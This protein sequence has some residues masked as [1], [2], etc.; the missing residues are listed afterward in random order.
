V[1]GVSIW[2]GDGVHLTANTT[3]SR[4]ESS[5]PTL[6]EADKA[7]S[8][9]TSVPA[10]SRLSRPRSPQAKRRLPRTSNLRRRFRRD[11]ARHHCGYRDSCRLHTMEVEGAG[12][13]EPALPTEEGSPQ[14]VASPGHTAAVGEPA[15]AAAAPTVAAN[16]AAGAASDAESFRKFFHFFSK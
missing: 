7:S 12:A 11:P 1:D 14:G 5:W 15:G 13:E 4:P 8:R 16:T 2:S 10:W 3:R 6:P 9:Q